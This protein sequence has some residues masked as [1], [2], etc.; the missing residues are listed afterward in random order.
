MIDSGFRDVTGQIQDLLAESPIA[1]VRRIRVEQDGNRV[2]LHGQVHSF[3]AKQMA[4]ETVRR[5]GQGL[6]IVN[7][8]NVD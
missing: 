1:D 5:A 4:Q 2:L 6:H 3:Y 7:S 8:V